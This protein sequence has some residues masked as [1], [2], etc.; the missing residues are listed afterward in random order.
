MGFFTDHCRHSHF[1]L[2]KYDNGCEPYVNK[3]ATRVSGPWTFGTR[4]AKRNLKGDVAR[5]NAE[6]L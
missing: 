2:V 1:E 3:E 4:P 6:I 5:V